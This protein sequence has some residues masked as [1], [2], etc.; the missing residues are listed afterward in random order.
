[1]R[2]PKL[3][4]IVGT[5]PEIIRLS[6]LIPLLDNHANHV[7]IHTGQNNDP[8]L[9]DVFFEE[10]NVREPD[11]YFGIDNSTLGSS[12]ANVLL[13]TEKVLQLENPDAVL[14]L[15]DTNSS[16]AA[17][18]AERMGIKVFH[19]EA[20]NRS[21]DRR[22]PEEINRKVVDHVSTFNLPYSE[23]A[24]M[25]LIAEGIHPRFIYKTGSPM[26]EVF[27]HYEKSILKSKIMGTLGLVRE[28]YF[29]VSIHRAEN[30]DDQN[31]LL[32]VL[33]CLS[34][35]H[36]HWGLP[37]VVSTH[38]RTKARLAQIK[39]KPEE[40]I[41][42]HEP[43]GFF[44]Y[45]N[46]Q[47]NSICVI[48]DSGTVSEESAVFGFRAVTLRESMERPEALEAGSVYLSGLGPDQLVLAISVT[49]KLEMPDRLPDDYVPRD[50]SNRVAKYILSTVA[51][52]MLS[53]S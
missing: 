44:D 26:R 37:I 11:Y 9:S 31:S 48:S 23:Q 5:R 3:L 4:T 39:W 46:L 53:V 38:P 22:V 13:E 42:L 41:I 25:N 34:A 21:F 27:D 51:R 28:Q 19:M 32:S 14:I 43:F 2:K 18:V 6:R 24:R 33:E 47:K 35:V 8:L 7:F 45:A 49:L 29:L 36:R 1:M 10:L 20:G 12:M 30:V 15:G 40:G 50:F 52:K 17:L 16:I